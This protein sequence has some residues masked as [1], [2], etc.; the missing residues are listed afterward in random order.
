VKR[1][2]LQSIFSFLVA[3]VLTQAAIVGPA[4]YSTDFSSAPPAT[5]WSTVS[6]GTSATVIT[7]IAAL[8][9]AAITNVAAAIT[10]ALNASNANPPNATGPAVWCAAGYLQTRPTGNAFAVLLGTFINGTSSNVTSVTISYDFATNALPVEQVQGQRAF[11]SLTG[12]AGSWTNIPEFSAAAVGSLTAT[13]NMVWNDGSPLYLL[14]VDDNG[15]G[16]PDT[17]CQIDNLTLTTS[18]GDPVST[19]IAIITPADGSNVVEGV[20]I[21]VAIA[22]SGGITTV[23]LNVDGSLYGTDGFPPFSLVLSNLAPGPHA[24]TAVGNGSVNS[25]TVNLTVLPN[26]PPLV[27]LVTTTGS[28]TL[29]GLNLTNTA[30]VTD[31]DPGGSIQRVEFYVDG[32]LR[33]TDASSPYT[34]ELCDVTAGTHTVAAVATDHFSARGTNSQTF[35]ATN[36][37]D[38]AVLIPNGSTWKYFDQGTDPGAT[39]AALAF[40]DTGWSNGVAELGYGDGNSAANRPETTLVSFGPS[41]TAKYPATYFRKK[42]N[43]GSPSSITNLIVRLLRDDGGIVYINGMDVFHSGVSNVFLPLTYQ[44]FTPPAVGDDGT[45]YQVTNVSP[46]VLVPGENIV[47]I[48]I[49]Q[50]AAG[51]S[52][53]SFDLMLW[54]RG[55]TGPPLGIQLVDATHV[56]ITWPAV[57]TDFDLESKAALDEPSWTPVTEPDA[58]DATLHHVV[59]ETT[60][61]H[62]FFRLRQ[63]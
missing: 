31:T 45:V 23:D 63:R 44:S 48:E 19:S 33:F 49:H 17:S 25:T 5:D 52:D 18:G 62:R 47:A 6:R 42:F 16:T 54:S 1:N 28:N 24:L 59:V 29:V 55:P 43:V 34:F 40:D 11:Y 36:P 4:G 61:E 35:T 12:S 26:N 15:S 58:P 39:W 14:F 3:P 10:T 7:N 32:T 20:N 60:W 27:T 30:T 8:D 2:I 22:T 51:S 41:T 57:I 50:D 9:A 21:P 53:I 13:L 38:V 37:T 46:S 56:D